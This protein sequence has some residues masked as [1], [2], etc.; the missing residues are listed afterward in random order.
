MK[1]TLGADTPVPVR[2]EPPPEQ[3]LT[4]WMYSKVIVVSL[5]LLPFSMYRS[6]FVIKRKRQ[7]LRLLKSYD[8][9]QGWCSLDFGACSC[10]LPFPFATNSRLHFCL[11]LYAI[12]SDYS[13]LL[14]L[15]IK[16]K[17]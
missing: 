16:E 11:L 10:N 4:V 6:V 15:A 8:S 9:T 1:I 3:G 5:F 14:W 2:G 7:S 12:T 13:N 17:V